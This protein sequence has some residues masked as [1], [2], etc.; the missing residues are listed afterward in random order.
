MKG[1]KHLLALIA[2]KKKK[3]EQEKVSSSQAIL[4]VSRPFSF[5]GHVD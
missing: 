3:K 1:K 2:K 5:G 4:P